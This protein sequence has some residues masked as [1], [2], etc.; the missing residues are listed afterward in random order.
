[1]QP[2]VLLNGGINTAG[3]FF[4]HADLQLDQSPSLVAA[5]VRWCRTGQDKIS[6]PG[7]AQPLKKQ[8]PTS[9]NILILLK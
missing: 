9:L 3:S 1:M 4:V 8:P 6:P 7:A 5:G 2:H